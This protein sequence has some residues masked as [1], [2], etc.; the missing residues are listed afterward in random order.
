MSILRKGIV[1]SYHLA[2]SVKHILVQSTADIDNVYSGHINY[3]QAEN[4][5]RGL[6]ECYVQ[7]KVKLLKVT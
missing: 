1:S 3:V 2:I 7:V 6:R 4:A 5:A